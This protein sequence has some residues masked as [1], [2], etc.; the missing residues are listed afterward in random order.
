L[1]VSDINYPGWEVL[2]DGKKQEIFP[3]QYIFKAIELQPGKHDII[4][5]Y[6]P[7]VFVFGV[8]ISCL[9][10]V[11]FV[12]LYI[13]AKLHTFREHGINEYPSNTKISR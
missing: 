8:V 12:C 13:I 9:S 7:R 2:V 11:C 3:A 10:I 4:F 6:R 1:M 5:T